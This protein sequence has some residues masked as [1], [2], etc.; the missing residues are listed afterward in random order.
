[1]AA[2]AA[3]ALLVAWEFILAV[4]IR[5]SPGVPWYPLPSGLALI[6]LWSSLR[7]RWIPRPFVPAYTPRPRLICAAIA[8]TLACL[9]LQLLLARLGRLNLTAAGRPEFEG[10]SI[11]P[12]FVLVAPVFSACA[13]ELIFRGIVQPSLARALRPVLAIIV[14]SLL[15]TIAHFDNSGFRILWPFYFVTS[16]FLGYLLLR[17]DG[18]LLPLTAHAGLNLVGNIPFLYYGSIDT[19]AWSPRSLG[20][21]ALAFAATAGVTGRLFYLDRRGTETRN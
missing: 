17:S 16:G 8:G 13:E 19:A 10:T 3:L 20:V 7:P 4:N 14:T 6:I 21:I 1:V 12:S 15:F 9:L 5:L 18:V 2:L 11:G